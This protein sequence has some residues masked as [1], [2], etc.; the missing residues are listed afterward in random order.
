[1]LYISLLM[2]LEVARPKAA[3]ERFFQRHRF[4]R[5]LFLFRAWSKK[6][7]KSNADQTLPALAL[8][9]SMPHHLITPHARVI[10]TF[11]LGVAKADHLKPRCTPSEVFCCKGSRG[12]APPRP[13]ALAPQDIYPK[14][15]DFWL[16]PSWP[17]W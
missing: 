7:Q 15:K 13:T 10:A 3:S 12:F 11:N 17:T 6:S 16:A 4:I 9:N 14:E 1:M 5:C 8:S 2:A